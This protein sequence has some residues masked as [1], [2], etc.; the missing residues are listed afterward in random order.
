[1]LTIYTLWSACALWLY[2]RGPEALISKVAIPLAPL[3]LVSTFLAFL[4]TLRSNQGLQRL[5]DGKKAFS[6]MVLYTRDMASLITFN[7]YPR[8]PQVGLKLIR[9][10]ALFGWLL[11]GLMR[12]PKVNGSD[13]DIIRT[14]LWPNAADADF[15]LRQRKRPV[16]VIS[17]LRQA[18]FHLAKDHQLSTAEEIALDHSTQSLN[19]CIMETEKI[20][21]TPIPPLYTALTGRLLLFYLGCLPFALRAANVMGGVGTVIICT[22][23]GYAMMAL[24]E[25]SHLCEQ[26]FRFMPLYMLSK[27]SVMDVADTLLQLPPD[28]ETGKD[29]S[30]YCPIYWPTGYKKQLDF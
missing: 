21:A 19:R 4:L 8:N 15:I 23:V 20:L 25:M 14:M 27:K 12:G 10:V 2:P 11:K 7:I 1:M 9:H 17:Q 13:E 6:E 5:M 29:V 26:P 18:F 28:Y 30:S 16:A 24:D 3:S 22:A